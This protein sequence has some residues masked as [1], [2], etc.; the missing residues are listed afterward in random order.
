MKKEELSLIEKDS[1][2]VISG[3]ITGSAIGIVIYAVVITSIYL[4][5]L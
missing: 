5:L 2:N 3:I 1:A 4:Y